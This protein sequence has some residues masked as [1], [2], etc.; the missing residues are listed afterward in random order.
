M[1]F[2]NLDAALEEAQFCAQDEKRKYIVKIERNGFKVIPKYR[3]GVRRY[4]HIEVGFKSEV[5]RD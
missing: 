5:Q 3:K 4:K 1:I 2:D